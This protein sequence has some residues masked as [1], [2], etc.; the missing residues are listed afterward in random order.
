MSPNELDKLAVSRNNFGE[1][2]RVWRMVLSP[3][4]QIRR[5][6]LVFVKATK[7]TVTEIIGK[8]I[9]EL[10]SVKVSFGLEAEF[11]RSMIY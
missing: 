6:L 8:E 2:L 1:W 5:D 4:K 9:E 3:F 7:A 10:K 11:S